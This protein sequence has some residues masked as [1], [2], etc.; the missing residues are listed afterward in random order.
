ME[1]D[2]RSRLRPRK[3]NQE[4]ET[5]RETSEFKWRFN[6]PNK[7]RKINTGES[8]RLVIPYKYSP[9]KTR[10]SKCSFRFG[11]GRLEKQDSDVHLSPIK[12]GKEEVHPPPPTPQRDSSMVLQVS[13]KTPIK[14]QKPTSLPAL[15]KKEDVRDEK[16]VPE[17]PPLVSNLG[18]LEGQ[19]QTCQE[20]DAWLAN[21]GKPTSN[22]KGGP[23]QL[24]L[25]SGPTGVGKTTAARLAL[26]Q[27]GYKVREFTN[28]AT[29]D[30]QKN[31]VS[32]YLWPLLMQGKEFG[33]P[34]AILLDEVE[35][36]SY[37]APPQFFGQLR[38]AVSGRLQAAG[39]CQVP[40]VLVCNDFYHSRLKAIRKHCHSVKFTSLTTDSCECLIQRWIDRLELK[41]HP[42]KQQ[43]DD[44][45]SWAGGDSRKLYHA[46]FLYS[47]APELDIELDPLDAAVA[48]HDVLT[49]CRNMMRQETYLGT[50]R[51][52]DVNPFRLFQMVHENY[53]IWMEKKAPEL[54]YQACADISDWDILQAGLFG[55]GSN[56]SEDHFGAICHRLGRQ[57]ATVPRFIQMHSFLTHH[58]TYKKTAKQ[59]AKLASK[60][61]SRLDANTLGLLVVHW[62]FLRDR[63][64]TQTL[65][66][67]DFDLLRR[68]QL[69]WEE[70]EFTDKHLHFRS[71]PQTSKPACEPG[72]RK[73]KND[74]EKLWKKWL[75]DP[76]D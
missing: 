7:R 11:G 63:G 71:I 8:V 56:M 12:P 6:Q 33:R 41:T 4:T 22:K 73:R 36:S 68:Y 70:L 9:P 1:S 21:V 76:L 65:T 10:S 72:K 62:K 52:L 32:E 37:S 17:L 54:T 15:G 2:Y 53:P 69:S 74:P 75:L 28:C 61:P 49:L 40:I 43:I 30:T 45:I 60:M 14:E 20:I 18:Q 48:D 34:L 50:Q 16:R 35:Q 55:S 38:N 19:Q 13:K 64:K 59:W 58:S 51:L 42:R 57:G 25:I 24:L 47:L 39:R 29:Y 27:R 44:W 3:P 5:M 67:H 23:G 46:L 26:A 66:P 31:F